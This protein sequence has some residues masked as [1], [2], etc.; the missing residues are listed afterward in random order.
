MTDIQ[1][2]DQAVVLVRAG[3]CT[4]QV[5]QLLIRGTLITDW[6]VVIIPQR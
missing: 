2:D 4:D 3:S 5:G 6:H 1:A